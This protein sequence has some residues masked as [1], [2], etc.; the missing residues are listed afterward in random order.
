MQLALVGARVEQYR[1]VLGAPEV[2]RTVPAVHDEFVLRGVVEAANDRLLLHPD[3]ELR[4][5]ESRVRHPIAQRPHHLVGVEN[6]RAVFLCEIWHECL[7][8]FFAE[9][10]ILA[11]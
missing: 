2:M 4:D 3:Q 10:S 11:I 6:V 8:P 9:L 1:L 5:L 7:Q